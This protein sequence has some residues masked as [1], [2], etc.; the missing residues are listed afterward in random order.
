MARRVVGVT[1]IILWAGLIAVVVLWGFQANA[2]GEQ[3][4]ENLP[5]GW[6]VEKSFVISKAQTMAISRKLG[7]RINKLTN[8][9]LSIGSKRLQVNVLYCPTSNA[10]DK[11]Y[12][13]ALEV[14]NG[15]TA[16]VARQGN[17]VI[18]FAKSDDINLMNQVRRTLGLEAVKLDSVARKLIKKNPAGWRIENSFVV[19]RTQTVAIGKKLGGRIKNL[20]NA[21]FSVNG[22]RFQVNVIECVTTVG[23]EKIYKSVLKMKGDPAFCI[24]LDNS[25]VEFVGDDVELAKRAVYELGIKPGGGGAG[26]KKISED[27]KLETMAKDFVGFLDKGNY[28]KAVANFDATMTKAMPAVKLKEVW[29]SI[30]AQVGPFV[31]QLGVRKEKTLQYDIVFVTCIFE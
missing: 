7:S 22:K 1:G 26:K 16:S 6:K 28:A 29:N 30:I 10:A 2:N 18:E 23:A 24:K 19:P 13:S 4:F 5:E 15:F 3:M 11:I 8:T 12:E 25:V 27:G 9:V 20:S 31:E 21:I 17:L 14:H